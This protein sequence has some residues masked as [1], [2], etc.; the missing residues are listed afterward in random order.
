MKDKVIDCFVRPI[1]FTYANGIHV[2]GKVTR[3]LSRESNRVDASISITG[4]TGRVWEFPDSSIETW[5][6]FNVIL[7]NDINAIIQE[8]VSHV[9]ACEAIRPED[10]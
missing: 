7:D 10:V 4:R 8:H 6:A 5:E 1:D 3:T 9:I 2:V